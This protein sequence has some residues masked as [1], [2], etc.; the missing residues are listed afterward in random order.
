VL[1]LLFTKSLITTE[2]LPDI[3]CFINQVDFTGILAKFDPA[4]KTYKTREGAT[5]SY[6]EAVFV[7]GSRPEDLENPRF[8]FFRIYK[9][10]GMKDVP[11][12]AICKFKKVVKKNEEDY[13][14][15]TSSTLKT[16]GLIEIT[17]DLL[18]NIPAFNE[19]GSQSNR[20]RS[21]ASAME[22]SDTST[23]TGKVVS[24]S[25]C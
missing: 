16:A 12:G 17:D 11:V 19:N 24:V 23:I 1:L 20:Q 5:R 22:S 3:V 18:A 21:L 14:M 8:I 13:Y 15:V 9:T 4:G 10:G 2:K 25:G 6:K 7:E